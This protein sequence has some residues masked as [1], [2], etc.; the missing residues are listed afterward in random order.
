MDEM[1]AIVVIEG[2]AQLFGRDGP[3]SVVVT[4]HAQSDLTQPRQVLCRVLVSCPTPILT[5]QYI[6]APMLTVFD[7]PVGT[8]ALRQYLGCC[9]FAADVVGHLD[10]LL[11][12]HLP[13]AD[14]LHD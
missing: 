7:A 14:H 10:R 2:G 13:C 11:V 8:N 4:E 5:E 1:S 12:P 6:Q 3:F 9:L